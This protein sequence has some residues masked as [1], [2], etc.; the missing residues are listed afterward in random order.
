MAAA[1]V[2]VVDKDRHRQ[3]QTRNTIMFFLL[4]SSFCD[5]VLLILFL[6]IYFLILFFLDFLKDAF[7]ECCIFPSV[8]E[9]LEL[10]SSKLELGS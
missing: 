1:V 4:N 5:L 8:I 10:L 7:F 9:N 3:T 2:V 6:I